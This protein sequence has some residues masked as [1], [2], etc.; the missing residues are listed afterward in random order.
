[1][2]TSRYDTA[3]QKI[4]FIDIT[5]VQIEKKNTG[6]FP[7]HKARSLQEKEDHTLNELTELK[8]LVKILVDHH[9]EEVLYNC[10]RTL[11]MLCLH[12]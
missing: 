10:E 9:Q 3:L 8:R 7:L 12:V 6:Y 4:V 5:I 1:M 11:V 2:C